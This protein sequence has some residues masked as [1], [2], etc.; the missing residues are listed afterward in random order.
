[1]KSVSREDTLKKEEKPMLSVIRI[2]G[3]GMWIGILSM[4]IAP[5][6]FKNVT[7]QDVTNVYAAIMDSIVI[8]LIVRFR[9]HTFGKS[10]RQKPD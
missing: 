6:L 9:W 2:L 1:V 4:A 5:L 7:E 10:R 8:M 3:L